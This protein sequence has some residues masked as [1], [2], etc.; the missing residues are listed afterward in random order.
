M[1]TEIL[2]RDLQRFDMSNS[3]VKI[4]DF[5]LRNGKSTISDVS[6]KLKVAPTNMYPIVKDMMGK[7]LVES[8]LTKPVRI[9]AV[10]LGKALDMLITK[11]KIVMRREVDSLEKI[12][13]KIIANSRNIKVEEEKAEVGRFQILKED[14]GYSK[15]VTSLNKTSSR[16]YL[17]MSKKNFVKLYYT[18]F[19]DKL[20]KRL[21]KR[22]IRSVFLLDENLRK[23][24]LEKIGAEIKFFKE[25]HMNDFIIFDDKEV[26]YYLD[27]QNPSEEDTVLWT[28][29]PSL[30][31]IF[32]NMFEINAETG[33]EN[34]PEIEEYQNSILSK[35]VVKKL[36]SSLFNEFEESDIK[37]ESG[38]KHRFDMLLKVD[39]KI[40]AV[41]FVYSKQQINILQ[42]LPFYVKAYDLKECVT[43]FIFVTNGQ[44][45]EE[46]KEFLKNN[47][48]NME[49]IHDI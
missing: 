14:H 34:S 47:K 44:L 38:F 17:S 19:L 48:L 16:L 43:K 25:E 21:E 40:I 42:L 13:E 28:T 3:E 29:L 45:D 1:A 39:S 36:F 11:Q 32:K 49:V 41:D 10:P 9:Y 26:F 15:L 7:G 31:T 37:G 33:T 35:K 24:N 5:L 22:D 8:T 46:T 20:K 12:K 18:D 6:R 27:K 2:E 30:V 23:M 4:Y